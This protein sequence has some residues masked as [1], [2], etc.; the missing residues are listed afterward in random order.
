MY[1]SETHEVAKNAMRRCAVPLESSNTNA[2]IGEANNKAERLIYLRFV[3]IQ[4]TTNCKPDLET[5]PNACV[6]SFWARE[7]PRRNATGQGA[8]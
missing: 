3:G 6:S 2:P 8:F 7:K 4:K 5:K 1:V